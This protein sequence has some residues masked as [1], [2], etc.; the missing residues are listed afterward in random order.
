LQ[1]RLRVLRIGLVGSPELVGLGRGL[2][3][4]AKRL[5]LTAKGTFTPTGG[6]ATSVTKTFTLKR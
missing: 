3:K 1:A 5:K 2:L 4:H 6:T